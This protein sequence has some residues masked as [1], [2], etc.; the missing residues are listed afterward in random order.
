M[1]RQIRDLQEQLAQVEEVRAGIGHNRPPE[2]LDDEPLS[3]DDRRE[4]T[5]ALTTLAS[6][7]AEPS[8]G[9]AAAIAANTTVG[10]KRNKVR[11]WLIVI[12]GGAVTSAIYDGI[13]ALA[14]Q[15]WPMI[16]VTLTNLFLKVTEWLA[17]MPF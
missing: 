11:N 15:V 8:D 10:D 4:L 3:R 17:S 14:L 1:Q 6:Q 9:G 13:K 16:E 7:P 2:A 5:A 12:G